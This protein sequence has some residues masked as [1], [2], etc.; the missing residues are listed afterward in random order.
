MIRI[1][2]HRD[3]FDVWC[4]LDQRLQTLSSQFGRSKCDP[5]YVASGCAKLRQARTDRMML[6]TITI[7]IVLVDLANG[8]TSP[9]IARITSGWM[10]TSAAARLRS[11]SVLPLH[12]CIRKQGYGIR[13][14]RNHE[15]L[16]GMSRNLDQYQ[17]FRITVRQRERLLFPGVAP[18]P[19]PATPPFRLVP[20]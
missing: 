19:P 2:D 20:Q 10:A 5:G 6:T 12:T 16:H 18:A 4:H 8:A 15:E 9:S 3:P 14:S 13:R 1:S 11:R 17:G 7:G